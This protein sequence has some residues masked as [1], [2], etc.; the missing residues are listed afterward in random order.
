MATYE[1]AMAERDELLGKVGALEDTLNEMRVMSDRAGHY[2][3]I[4]QEME[5]RVGSLEKELVLTAQ[6]VSALEKQLKDSHR[7]LEKEQQQREKLTAKLRRMNAEQSSKES[8]QEIREQLLSEMEAKEKLVTELQSHSE[9]QNRQIETEQIEKTRLLEELS[10]L[11]DRFLS[12]ERQH[13]SSAF[14]L[15]RQLSVARNDLEECK[16]HVRRL[17]L[18]R[19]TLCE[20]LHVKPDPGLEFED[21]RGGGTFGEAQSMVDVSSRNGLSAIDALYLKNVLFKCLEATAKQKTVERDMLLPALATV[22]GASPEEFAKLKKSLSEESAGS[23]HGFS[24]WTK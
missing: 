12:V 9:E 13:A 18:E 6:Q 4:T 17:E 19:Q 14:H 3:Q 24:F 2:Q 5:E 7:R 1:A 22:L 16:L 21:A 8:S 20:K 23:K 15:K 11:E 10:Q